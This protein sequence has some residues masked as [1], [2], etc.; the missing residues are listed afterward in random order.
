MSNR[1]KK[2]FPKAFDHDKDG[3]LGIL[4]E[5]VYSNRRE[6]VGSKKA[7]YSAN[8]AV[9]AKLLTLFIEDKIEV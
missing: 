9:E 6:K 1:F 7:I 3:K 4:W 5:S 2:H 8:A